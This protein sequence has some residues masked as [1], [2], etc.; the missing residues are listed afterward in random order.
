ME[1]LGFP[2]FTSPGDGTEGG[3]TAKPAVVPEKSSEGVGSPFILSEAL[4]VL[5]AKLVCRIQ[6]L[7]DNMEEERRR[8]SAE[9]GS[10]FNRREVPDILSWLQCFNLYMAV[11]VLVHPE[12]TRELLAYQ[13]L[14]AGGWRLYDVDFRQ[15]IR[16]FDSVNFARINQWLYSTTILAFGGGKTKILPSLHALRPHRRDISR[17]VTVLS[18][19]EGEWKYKV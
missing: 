10:H 17:V 15:Q 19:A 7:K 14:I 5:S 6:L 2:V 16:S 8:L 1:E 12:K 3:V 13:A 4:P 18:R 11:V 9:G